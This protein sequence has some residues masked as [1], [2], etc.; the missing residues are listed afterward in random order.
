MKPKVLQKNDRMQSDSPELQ[1]VLRERAQRVI[2]GKAEA[3]EGALSVLTFKAGGDRF[4]L[5]IEF[6][7]QVVEAG[8]IRA[9]PGAPAF[10]RGISNVR[11]EILPV[12]DL[13]ELLG[14][15]RRPDA[16]GAR[17]LIIVQHQDRRPAFLVDGCGGLRRLHEEE[18][19][20]VP[21]NFSPR[22]SSMV[23]F[24]T[25]DGLLVLNGTA[26]LGGNEILIN[27]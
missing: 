13:R 22:T 19:G 23:R 15:P 24:F 21:A 14:L 20:K 10:L 26:L 2:S 1:A 12:I 17:Q 27:T 11:A 6:V 5:E 8:I 16:P 9:L 18:C 7:S 25:P 4:A 3:A